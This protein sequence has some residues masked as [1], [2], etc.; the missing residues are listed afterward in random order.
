M[1]LFSGRFINPLLIALATGL[2]LGLVMSRAR[3]VTLPGGALRHSTEYTLRQPE[4]K[5]G[6][7]GLQGRGNVPSGKSN[8]A[9]Y[10]HKREQGWMAPVRF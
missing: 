3:N 9:F 4:K 2:V 1:G 8:T 10:W 5:V 7:V 6:V